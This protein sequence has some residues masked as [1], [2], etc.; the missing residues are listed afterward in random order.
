MK[1]EVTL[2][3]YDE[4]SPD[5]VIDPYNVLVKFN[6]YDRYKDSNGEYSS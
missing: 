4:S 6:V 3:D 5:G 2:G 1:F